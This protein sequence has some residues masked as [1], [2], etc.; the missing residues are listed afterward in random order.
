MNAIEHLLRDHEEIEKLFHQFTEAQQLTEQQA[1]TQ[2]TMG[3]IMKH[4]QLEEQILF[5][6]LAEKGGEEGREMV[7]EA[8]EQHRVTELMM[9]RLQK[10][11]PDEENFDVR[12]KV[13]MESTKHHFL[14]EE[15]EFFP[16]AKKVLEGELDRLGMEMDNFEKQMIK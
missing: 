9:D 8:I 3:E 6:V 1:I 13:L 12:F 11:A 14:E 5:P 7:R 4:A 15:R 10:T 16:R 2:T